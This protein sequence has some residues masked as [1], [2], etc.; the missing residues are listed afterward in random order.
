[1]SDQKPAGITPA[2]LSARLK[3]LTRRSN[4]RDPVALAE[5][6]AF[7]DEHSEVWQTIGD[8]GRIAEDA[9]IDSLAG[10]EV[11]SRESFKRHVAQMK[12]DLAGEH[13]TPTECLL[14]DLIALTH[15]SL[16]QAVIASSKAG[17]SLAVA[18]AHARRSEVEQQRYVQA[19]RTL[20]TLR[21]LVPKGLA[22]VDAV[23]LFAVPPKQKQA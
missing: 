10:G 9:Y 21:A 20:A 7:L 11:L 12:A 19:I 15:L 1:M 3:E 6:R 14:V 23:K 17:T 8:L 22:P 13:A 5:L 4:E 18:Q 16:H 2:T